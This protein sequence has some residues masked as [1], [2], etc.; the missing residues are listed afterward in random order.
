MHFRKCQD[1]WKQEYD[2]SLIW[3]I[4]AEMYAITDI[5]NLLISIRKTVTSDVYKWNDCSEYF[6]L[7][8]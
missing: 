3:I 5:G 1:H 4:K 2:R 6:S 7:M 8:L